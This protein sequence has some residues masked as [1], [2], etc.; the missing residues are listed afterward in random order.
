MKYSRKKQ[1]NSEFGFSLANLKIPRIGP[2]QAGNLKTAWDWSLNGLNAYATGAT[3]QQLWNSGKQPAPGVE[4]SVAEQEILQVK[5]KP[6]KEK[7]RKK[8]KSVGSKNEQAYN[9]ENWNNV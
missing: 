3:I 4:P 6:V 1:N 9:L 2:Q 5:E 8:T 7:Y